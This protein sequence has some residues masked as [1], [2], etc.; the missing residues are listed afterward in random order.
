MTKS[1]TPEWNP[2]GIVGDIVDERIVMGHGAGGRKMHRLIS[3]VFLKHFASPALRKLADSAVLG[4]LPGTLAMTTDSY[5]VQPLFFPGGDIGKLAV[6][7]TVNDLAVMGAAPRYMSLAFVIREGLEVLKLEA[8]CRSIG[9]A[10]RKAGVQ[11][12]TGDTKVIERGENEELYVNTTG[13]GSLI[14]RAKLGP[15][16]VKP[17]D[18]ILINGPVGEHEAAIAVARG[19]YRFRGK[20]E[21][22][23]A[24]LNGFILPL[25]VQPGVRLMRDPTRGGLATTINEFAEAT[26]LGFIVDEAAL[27]VSRHVRGVAD[28][29]GLDPLYMANEGKVIVI[30]DRRAEPRLLAKM[31]RHQFGRQAASIGEVV[32][33]PQGVWLKTRLGSLRPLIM[34][35][36]EQLPR[37]C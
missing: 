33:K 9:A 14:P 18:A 17:G 10:C 35:E 8:I 2:P 26:G 15:E 23:C 27:V 13:I 11:V 21:S 5:V 34:L 20:A 16:R 32:R 36:G 19:A 29:L 7:G 31:R 30:A 37:I 4:R 25:L 24:A 28:L 12:V 22:D 3:K 1:Q 6:C